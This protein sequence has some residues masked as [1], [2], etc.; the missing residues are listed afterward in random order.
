MT[1]PG[2]YQ[3]G[4]GRLRGPDPP[5]AP[6]R[7]RAGAELGQDSD[8]VGMSFG[9]PG[10]GEV[11]LGQ[12]GQDGPALTGPAATRQRQVQP[13]RP[14]RVGK[15]RGRGGARPRTGAFITAKHPGRGECP[16]R[17]DHFHPLESSLRCPPPDRAN[18]R[19]RRPQGGSVI[20]FARAAPHLTPQASRS[21]HAS[22]ASSPRPPGLT[23]QRPATSHHVPLEDRAMA[24][25]RGEAR[26]L[27]RADSA[28]ALAADHD[29]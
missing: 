10:Q 13:A 8:G 7:Q 15:V 21:T 9:E 12:P 26:Q 3:P 22:R 27:A 23:A 20:M 29:P 2:G 19:R 24:L 28:G 5:A 14:D 4:A 25:T 17:T 6:A 18:I 16:P 11:V 1:G